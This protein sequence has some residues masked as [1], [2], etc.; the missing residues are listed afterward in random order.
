M[1]VRELTEK[2]KRGYL[3]LVDVEGNEISSG[4]IVD[5]GFLDLEVISKQLVD[6]ILLLVKVEA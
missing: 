4:T 5:E 3:T 1:K 6:D 2:L